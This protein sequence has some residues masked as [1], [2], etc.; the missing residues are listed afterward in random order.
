MSYNY[1]IDAYAWIEYF[2]GSE[3]GATVKHYIEKEESATPT[4]VIAELSR[5]LL[6][7]VEIGGETM[8]GRILKLEFV[9]ASTIIVDLS[10]DIA[11]RS[12]EIDLKRKR[13]IKEWGM[14]DSIILAT[15]RKANAKVVTGDQHFADLEDGTVM[16]SS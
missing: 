4:I 2:R 3:A 7:E 1:V 16:M 8:E 13:D 9:K 14:S 6:K 15:A 10:Q 11:E 12:G 5:R